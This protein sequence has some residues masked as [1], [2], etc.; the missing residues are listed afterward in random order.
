MVRKNSLVCC[1][2]HPGTL[3]HEHTQERIALARGVEDVKGKSAAG[4]RAA[5]K[6]ARPR[7]MSQAGGSPMKTQKLTET[8]ADLSPSHH[9]RVGIEQILGTKTGEFDRAFDVKRKPNLNNKFLFLMKYNVFLFCKTQ[10][11]F[12]L[13]LS[14][15]SL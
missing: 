8:S 9:R 13:E 11:E 6:G 15:P 5:K 12:Q 2:A 4:Q 14:V 1:S 3:V 7:L 10:S